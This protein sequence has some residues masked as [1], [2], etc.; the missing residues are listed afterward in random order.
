MY[1]ENI[2][3]TLR[4]PFLVLNSCL[5]VKTAN[6]SFF[7][8]FHVSHEETENR[9]VYDLGDGQWD[10]PLLRTLLNE[11]LSKDLPIHDFVVEH[12]FPDIGH[13]SM[14]LNARKFL[15]SPTPHR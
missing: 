10:I 1:A 11:V 5:R 8:S 3:A 2:I 12:N 15:Q 13:R 7:E 9:L 14:L 4:E 6:P